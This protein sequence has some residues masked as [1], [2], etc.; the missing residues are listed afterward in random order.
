MKRSQIY[1]LLDN[2]HGSN[3]PGKRSPDGKLLEYKYAREITKYI[4]ESL[5]KLNIPNSLLVPEC[6]DISLQ[7]R[8]S[9]AN[10]IYKQNKAKGITTIL[11]SIHCNA[12]GNGTQWMNAK[13]WSIW[14]SKGQT[15]GDK[16][17][18]KIWEAA[19]EVLTPLNQT[20]RKEDYNDGD[21][22]YES[23][24]YILKKT[25]CPAVLTENMFQDNK[26]DVEFL[27]SKEGKTAI[28]KLH[29]LGILKY[30]ETY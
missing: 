18:D 7:T 6:T 11:I 4:S 2:G 20:V 27:L 22:D 23:D 16:L 19:K 24:F 30:I 15:A 9:R 26:D 28:T 14:T 12:L 25:A 3:T 1:V 8:V 13:G 10:N 5:N 29:I 21:P 17:A